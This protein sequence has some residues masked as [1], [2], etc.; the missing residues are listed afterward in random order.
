MEFI[1]FDIAPL[2]MPSRSKE[3]FVVHW[4]G[5]VVF[6]PTPNDCIGFSGLVPEP[7]SKF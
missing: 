6:S 2:G 3:V 4:S 7:L 1:K 5:L